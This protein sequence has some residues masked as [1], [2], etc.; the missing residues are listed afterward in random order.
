MS[1]GK[2]TRKGHLVSKLFLVTI[3][4]SAFFLAGQATCFATNVALQW[5]PNTDANLAGYKVYY[6]ADSSTTPFNGTGS[7]MDVSN[8]TT[9]TVSNL[10]PG[11][12][13]YF[14][15]SAYDTS[16]VESS[17]SNIV[18]VPE[19]VLPT[20]SL[21]YPANNTTASGTL[22][23]TASAGD[24]VGVT[25][26]EFYVN[27]VLNGTDTSTPYIYSWNTSSLAAGNYTLMAKAYDAA[28]NVDQSSNVSVTVVNDTTPPTVSLTAPGN[29]A[30]VSGTVAITASAGDNVGV[31][32]VEFYGNGVLLSAG[33]VAPYSYN[34]NT[35]SVANG[36]YTLT[37]KVYDAAGNVGQSGNVT[38]TL[39]NTAADT[40]P[41]TVTTFT[42][43]ATSSSL[44]IPVTAFAATDNVGVT[45]YCVTSTNAAT[46]CDWLSSSNTSFTFGSTGTKTA[47]AWAKDAAGKVSSSVSATV[48]ILVSDTT[49]PTV[50]ISSPAGNT[51]VS[52]TVT[53]STSASDNVGV[54]RVEFYVNGV[55][56]A[57][58]TASPYT[59]SWNATAVA[60]GTYILTAKAYDAAGNVGQSG[61]VT[62]TVNS[63]AADTTPPTVTIFTMPATSSSLTIPV[64]AFA[65]TDNVGVTAYCVTST[66]AATNCDWLSSPNTSFTFG[67]TGTNTAYAWAKDATGKVS[68]SVSATVNILVSDTT[69][70]TVSINS[71]AAGS[72]VRSNVTI[73][74]SASDNVGVT[75]MA[76]YI[77]NVLKVTTSSNTLAWTWNT[78]SYARGSHVITV[79]AFDAANNM[80]TTSITVRK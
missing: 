61:N 34:W 60:N 14:A 42:M 75:K 21:S 55:L 11:R 8:Q 19:S 72:R 51:N 47:Y 35:A 23:V 46:N 66:N 69:P 37:A 32:K 64:T 18:T 27:G 41:P 6:Q 59:V 79:N 50:S 31:S 16:G 48:N 7:P 3:F 28:G 76:L 13:Y 38:V 12:T 54:T 25:K 22:S 40:M 58:D 29:N 80:D 33:N 26:V 78:N 63:T 30:T 5:N 57:T 56:Q 53:V 52:G 39:N 4:L 17:Y 68:S 9:A 36:G 62:V 24:N 73:K 77:D 45:A 70:P 71:P 65:A 44:T 2:A 1:I 67:S 49:P 43:P 10:D 20:V 15:V 74:A